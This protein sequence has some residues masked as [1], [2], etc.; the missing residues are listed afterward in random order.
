M[1]SK[2][3]CFI[4][5]TLIIAMICAVSANAFYVKNT[6]NSILIMIENAIGTEDANVTTAKI[7]NE[8]WEER[9]SVLKLSLSEKEMAE[10][11]LHIKEA[12]ISAQSNNKEEY[13]KSMA[14]LRRAIEGI[15]KR[16]EFSLENIL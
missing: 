4:A 10:I 12:T 15:K 2:V 14:R 5:V 16:E 7:I 3:S 1:S 11:S 9:T 13:E 8:Y 6:V